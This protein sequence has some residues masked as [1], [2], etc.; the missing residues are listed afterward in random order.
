MQPQFLT[1]KQASERFPAFS[2]AA[3]RN[4]MFNRAN[5]G[6]ARC[7]VRIG[8]RVLIDEAEFIAFMRDHRETKAAA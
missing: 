8:K 1:I 7:V 6:F 3:L 2:R 4:M 5:N